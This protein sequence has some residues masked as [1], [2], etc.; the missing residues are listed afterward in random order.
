MLEGGGVMKRSARP[1]NPFLAAA[2]GYGSL[3]WKVFPIRQGFKD[4]PHLKEWG[5][6]STSSPDQI[7]EWWTRWPSA[8]IGL[9]CGPSSRRAAEFA[10]PNLQEGKKS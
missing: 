8:N 2:L 1:V 4:R 6:L 5:A 9:A 3:G 10:E 7:T